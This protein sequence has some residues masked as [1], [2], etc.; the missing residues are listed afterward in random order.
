MGQIPLQGISH[1]AFGLLSESFQGLYQRQPL[2]G[3]QGEEKFSMQVLSEFFGIRND[4]QGIV[5]RHLRCMHTFQQLALKNLAAAGALG[6]N[7]A[8]P[9]VEKN[10]PLGEELTAQSRLL[11]FI[12]SNTRK[13]GPPSQ[14]IP[15]RVQSSDSASVEIVEQDALGVESGCMVAPYLLFLLEIGYQVAKFERAQHAP[16]RRHG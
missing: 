9:P 16:H 4:L 1:E 12:K 3:W 2:E 8:T 10:T 6:I 7:L 5:V 15:Q 11:V 14:H 13:K